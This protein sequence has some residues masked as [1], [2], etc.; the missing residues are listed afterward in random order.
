VSNDDERDQL[1]AAAHR[2]RWWPGALALVALGLIYALLPDN[3]RIGPAWAVLAVALVALG[4]AFVQH[5]RGSMLMR[6]RFL[7]SGL[8]VIALAISVSAFF[9]IGS[10]LDKRTEAG[11]LLLDAALVWVSNILVFALLYWE[12]DGG[13]PA[14]RHAAHC[15]SKDFVFPQRTLGEAESDWMPEFLDYVFLAFN[16]STAFSPTDTPVLGR[17]AKVLSMWQSLVSLITAG[18]LIARAINTI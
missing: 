8:A 18:I 3:L 7:V 10:L 5:R 14:H 2:V 13:G 11:P 12:T 4:G 9:L 1:I 15:S 6:R 17:R 16:T